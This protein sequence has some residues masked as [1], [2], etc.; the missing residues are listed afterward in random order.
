MTEKTAAPIALFCA[1][2]L[3]PGAASALCIKVPEANLRSGPGT[4]YEKSWTVYKYMP[5]KKIGQQGSWYQ[6]RDVDGD[7]HWV[8]SRLVTRGMHCAAVKVDKANVR[9]GPGTTYAKSPLSPVER[10]Y[11]FKITGSKDGWVKV[12]DEVFNDGW[13]AKA[14]LWIQ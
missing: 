5:L 2:L 7:T 13:M 1:A 4:R 12:Q 9:T 11:S 8:Y 6:V 10:Y 3:L 14:L